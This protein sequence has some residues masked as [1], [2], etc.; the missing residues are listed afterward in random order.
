M[1][2]LDYDSF[3]LTEKL[4]K[5]SSNFVIRNHNNI[6]VKKSKVANKGK[7]NRGVFANKD[8]NK[9]EIVEIC[10]IIKISNEDYELITLTELGHY[11]FRYLKNLDFDFNFHSIFYEYVFFLTT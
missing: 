3:K 4:Q 1:E 2:L 9:D 11:L 8:M 7:R 10:P 5:I 6:Y